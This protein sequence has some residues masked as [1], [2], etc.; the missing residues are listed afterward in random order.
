LTLE[1]TVDRPSTSPQERGDEN[2]NETPNKVTQTN[3]PSDARREHLTKGLDL[4]D[5]ALCAFRVSYD[6]TRLLDAGENRSDRAFALP[7]ETCHIRSR[8]PG[9]RL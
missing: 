9:V 5:R 4:S 8:V 1:C 7:R 3:R 2:S 6:P